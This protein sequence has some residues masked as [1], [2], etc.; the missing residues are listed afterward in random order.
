MSDITGEIADVH[1][2]HIRTDTNIN[3]TSA[4][5]ERDHASDT[6]VAKREQQCMIWR[7]PAAKTVSLTTK[8][9]ST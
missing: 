8:I 7:R 6:D 9:E 4:T 1:I 2:V 3:Y 5:T